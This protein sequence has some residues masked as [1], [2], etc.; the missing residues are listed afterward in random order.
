VIQVVFRVD[1]EVSSNV[2]ESIKTFS[3]VV[4]EVPLNSVRY[5]D[6]VVEASGSDYR[7]DF[8]IGNKI[9]FYYDESLEM[10]GIILKRSHLSTG[11][12]RLE[13]V[14][15][16]ERK[17][18]QV[19]A[20]QHNWSSTDTSGVVADDATNLLANVSTITKGTVEDQTVNAFRSDLNQSVLE[21]VDKLCTLTSQDYS[22]DDVN[23]ELDVEDHKG[24]ATSV[25]DLTDGVSVVNVLDEEDETE[26]IKKVTVVGAGEG[27]QQISTSTNTTAWTQGDEEITR[28]DKSIASEQEALDLAEKILAI[29]SSTKV[30]Y[31]FEVVNPSLSF[32]LG[33]VITLYSERLGISGTEL[34]IVKFKRVVSPNNQ[35]L[36][37]VVRG[38]SD[39]EVAEDTYKKMMAIKRSNQEYSAMTQPIYCGTICS[40][41]SGAIIPA[42]SY[43]CMSGSVTDGASCTDSCV[44]VC[45]AGA[46]ENG[47][48]FGPYCM[49][50]CCTGAGWNS[51]CTGINT[52]SNP[53]FFHGIFVNL[54][55]NYQMDGTTTGWVRDCYYVRA[56]NCTDGCYY[57]NATGILL[58]EGYF[59]IDNCHRHDIDHNHAY[60]DCTCTGADCL[61]VTC[62]TALC[63]D[64]A[65]SDYAAN[66]SYS[67]YIHIPEN[68]SSKTYTL[69]YRAT[70]CCCWLGNPELQY[71]YH[72]TYGHCHDNSNY[73]I[74]FNHGHSNNLSACV[75]CTCVCFPA[76]CSCASLNINPI[77]F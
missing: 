52:S 72:A 10:K 40:C 6:I 71:S 65:S 55:V 31:S 1:V 59:Q 63:T 70:N 49:N 14:G 73:T 29:Y 21:A 56:Y 2:F 32:S 68:W 38:T 19:N 61:R 69:Q 46:R 41:I 5:F 17:L 23:D 18:G 8:A 26:T 54:L 58:S 34:R 77:T 13:G 67:T 20:P 12:L 27:E 43:T 44:C 30:N 74:D 48:Y 53:F 37:L 60:R 66:I 3:K 24:S 11:E 28:V 9:Y 39:R 25:A 4:Y 50:A 16:G 7:S 35:K 51:T 15:F 33:D 45:Y 36:F 47:Y 42:S 22:F 64:Y 57:P 75:C 76:T 62:C